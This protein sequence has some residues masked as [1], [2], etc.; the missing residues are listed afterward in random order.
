MIFPLS[1]FETL[2]LSAKQLREKSVCT[3]P[4]FS[5]PYHAPAIDKLQ[6]RLEVVWESHFRFPRSAY[7]RSTFLLMVF[8]WSNISTCK[9]LSIGRYTRLLFWF[10]LFITLWESRWK[11]PKIW[12]KI[13]LRGPSWG[14]YPD[15]G[16]KTINEAETLEFYISLDIR[17]SYMDFFRII[18]QPIFLSLLWSLRQKLLNSFV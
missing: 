6:A 7:K 5:W 18:G 4:L 15:L 3:F 9:N 10:K 2:A 1:F 8:L 16:W 12:S 11:V 17:T 14:W 13:N